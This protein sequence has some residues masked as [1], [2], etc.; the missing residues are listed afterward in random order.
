MRDFGNI[1]IVVEYD[2]DIMLEFDYLVDIGLYVGEYG[3]FIMVVGI[4]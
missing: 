2:Y 3:G 4:L 1:L